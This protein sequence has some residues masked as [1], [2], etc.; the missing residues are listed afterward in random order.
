MGHHGAQPATQQLNGVTQQ[1]T[2]HE[3]HATPQKEAGRQ[4]QPPSP[5]ARRTADPGPMPPLS[6]TSIHEAHRQAS[7]RRPG[8]DACRT[9]SAVSATKPD[10]NHDEHQNIVGCLASPR[11]L[12]SNRGGGIDACL[13]TAVSAVPPAAFHACIQRACTARRARGGLLARARPLS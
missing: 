4:V 11:R 10:K 5:A 3:T 8:V 13:E 9:R 2:R 12:D 7:I 6:T 1:H